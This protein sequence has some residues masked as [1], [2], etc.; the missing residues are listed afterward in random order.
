MAYLSAIF[1][2]IYS[3]I[4]VISTLP[5]TGREITIL[6]VMCLIAHNLIVETA[7]QRK[8][9]SRVGEMLALRLGVSLLAGFLLNLMV[10]ASVGLSSSLIANEVGMTLQATLV[11]W[12]K[13]SAYLALKIV[14]LVSLLMILQRLL[15][16]F[17]ILAILSTGLK[18][19]LRPFGLP[20]NTT[21]LWLVA[22]VLGLAYGSAVMMEE[23]SAGRLSREEADLLNYHVAI[24]HS[25]LEDVLLFVA[26]GAPAAWLLF[27]RLILAG[28][29]VWTVRVV[30]YGNRSFR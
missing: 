22:N 3:A 16:A 12:L 1:L 14:V 24:S 6:A 28:I 5:L 2:N 30:K 7:V 20:G 23:T 9:G 17:G 8:T 15:Q 10:P 25:N 26:I 19:I 11:V 4:A 18:P 21:F 27:P 13:S 29:A